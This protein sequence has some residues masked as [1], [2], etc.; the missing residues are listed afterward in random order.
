LPSTVKIHLV[1]NVSRVR[2]YKDQVE[3]QKKERLEPVIIEGEE[4]YEVEKILNK[5]NFRGKDQYLVWWKDYMAEEDTW[6]PRENLGNMEDLVKEFKEEYG[7]IGRVRK[8][9]NEKEDRREELLG[10]YMAKMLYG[11]DDKRFDKEYWGWLE[12]NW[13][14]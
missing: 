5:K 6:E 8:R 4:E 10:R 12:R 7:K 3:G 14:K 9:R 11:W 1:V 2:R 13:N